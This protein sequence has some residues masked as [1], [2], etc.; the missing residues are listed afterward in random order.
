MMLVLLRPAFRALAGQAGQ[1]FD[2]TK[3]SGWRHGMG[4]ASSATPTSCTCTLFWCSPGFALLK[5]RKGSANPSNMILTGTV[6]LVFL[7]LCSSSL[8]T[9]AFLM[10][11]HVPAWLGRWCGL[12]AYFAKYSTRQH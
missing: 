4:G 9:F 7:K 8:P 3:A 11:Q 1:E 12:Q 6:C 2:G 5:V 10:L